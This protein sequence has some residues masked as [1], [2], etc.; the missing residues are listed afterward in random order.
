MI[1]ASYS[2]SSPAKYTSRTL[3]H[4]L[5]VDHQINTTWKSWSWKKLGRARSGRDLWSGHCQIH[6]LPRGSA[7]VRYPCFRRLAAILGMLNSMNASSDCRLQ[8]DEIRSSKRADLPAATSRRLQ[9]SAPSGHKAIIQ[10]PFPSLDDGDISPSYHQDLDGN[11]PPSSAIIQ[12]DR[13]PDVL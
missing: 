3:A 4:D 5:S 6:F 13:E 2:L 8:I 11:G 9:V 10:Y 1:N 7:E 12:Q